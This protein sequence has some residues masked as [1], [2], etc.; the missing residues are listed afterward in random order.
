MRFCDNKVLYLSRYNHVPPCE[1]QMIF[2]R[3]IHY[4]IH[5]SPPLVPTLSQINPLH[6]TP[7]NFSKI[8]N[9]NTNNCLLRN[10]FLTCI[11]YASHITACFGSH[12]PSSG[13]YSKI[14]LNTIQPPKSWP[15]SSLFP[16][17]FPNLYAFFFSPFVQH[18]LPIPS[19]LTWQV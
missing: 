2:P 16:S 6:T 11:Y 12:E 7:S 1:S 4:R 13:E 18:D 3:N 15:S 17:G 9:K 10:H 5:K 14:H 19:S 8:T